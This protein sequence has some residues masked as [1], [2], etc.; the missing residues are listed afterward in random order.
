MLAVTYSDTLDCNNVVIEKCEKA[1]KENVKNKI[2][3]N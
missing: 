1:K 3:V 2:G